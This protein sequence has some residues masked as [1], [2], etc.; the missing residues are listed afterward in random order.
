[1]PSQGERNQLL[2]AWA[3]K[4]LTSDILSDDS[5]YKYLTGT[6]G[7]NYAY[8]F[9]RDFLLP[10]AGIRNY[11][12]YNYSITEQGK[13]AHYWS[14]SPHSI[15]SDASHYLGFGQ[16]FVRAQ[17]TNNR[18]YGM[19]VRCF[20]NSQPMAVNGKCGGANTTTVISYP[21]TG[22][23][24][25]GTLIDIDTVGTDG[26]YNWTC[27][28]SSSSQSCTANKKIDGKCGALDEITMCNLDY[29]NG[30][31]RFHM[32]SVGTITGYSAT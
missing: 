11:S 22:L 20:K 12:S 8:Q 25:T 10:L 18:A 1:V 31:I 32:C 23:C 15:N 30:T 6:V 28:G 7:T 5:G 26:M 9:N 27:Q 13:T 29:S 4:T 2:I 16:N 17:G 14:S 19:S 24:S 3:T 21:T